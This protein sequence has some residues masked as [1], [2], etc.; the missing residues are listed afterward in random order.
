MFIYT[1]IY[2]LFC[3]YGEKAKMETLRML[4][5]STVCLREC[6]RINLFE[7]GVVIVVVVKQCLLLRC[8]AHVTWVLSRDL[9]ENC[10]SQTFLLLLFCL[11]LSLSYYSV[12]CKSRCRQ[13][14]FRVKYAKR[15][16]LNEKNERITNKK[17]K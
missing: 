1:Y 12:E 7:V 5:F 2:V 8:G 14:C 17:V 6:V 13:Y 16:L 10:G 4:C 11:P 15:S 9:I 3:L